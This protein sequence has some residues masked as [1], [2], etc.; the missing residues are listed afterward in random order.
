[1]SDQS[2]LAAKLK[3]YVEII[4]EEYKSY[5]PVET[6][7]YLD[8]I[9]DF[10]SVINIEELGTISMFV[11]DGKMY[12]PKE[13]YKILSYM[14]TIP[15]FGSNKNHQTHTSK[16]II[17][18]DNTFEDYIKHVFKKG[19]TPVEFF[20]ETILHE[21]MH[22]CGFSGADAFSEGLTELKTRELALKYGLVT[23]ACGYPKE[24]KIANIFQKIF[25][26]DL[27]NKIAVTSNHF[28]IYKLLEK[29]H[30]LEAVSLYKEIV[31]E[32]AKKFEPYYNKSYS[33]LT[34]PIKKAKEYSKIDYSE[35]EKIL[36][37]YQNKQ[38]LKGVKK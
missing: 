12:F 20:L 10:N 8:S 1:M 6:M 21:A 7:I 11:R 5:I 28:E 27:T 29:T 26:E 23:S 34:G 3:E 16:T 31:K 9:Q 2:I 37:E 22:L 13:A 14:R 36:T 32:M 18:N 4:K 38:S 30:G 15:G 24:V 25:G 17:E 35:L 33:G 19:L